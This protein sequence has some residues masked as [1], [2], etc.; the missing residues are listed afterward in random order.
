M[1]GAVTLTEFLKNIK[2]NYWLDGNLL[3]I[4]V[5]MNLKHPFQ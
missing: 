1:D 2:K 4:Y 3:F 5:S